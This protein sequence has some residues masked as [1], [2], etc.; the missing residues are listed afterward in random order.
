MMWERILEIYRELPAANRTPVAIA[1]ALQK[2][3]CH[4]NVCRIACV[5][6]ATVL[7]ELSHCDIEVTAR[8]F[9]MLVDLSDTYGVGAEE[10]ALEE[11]EK[12]IRPLKLMHDYKQLQSL[13]ET[14]AR[15]LSRYSYLLDVDQQ[16]AS[17][18]A[19][20]RRRAAAANTDD[21]PF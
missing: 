10:R 20:H 1:E 5:L 16:I 19:K 12:L 11:G 9:R 2:Q 6:E 13:A 14:I 15:F 7:E 21:D 17:I 4:L 8:T 18:D 3:G